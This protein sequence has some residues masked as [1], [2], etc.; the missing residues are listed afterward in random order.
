MGGQWSGDGL[1]F[2]NLV[3]VAWICWDVRFRKKY[4]YI[5][6]YFTVKQKTL[7]NGILL[8]LATL[9]NGTLFFY[10]LHLKIFYFKTNRE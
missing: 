7:E 3:V 5:Y 8:F 9:E 4:I 1:G 10:I 2:A 6:I